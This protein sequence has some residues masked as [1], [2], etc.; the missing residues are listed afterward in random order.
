MHAF[1]KF[2]KGM[3]K[4]PVHWQLWLLFLVS[5]NL[6]VPLFFL[7]RIEALLVVGVLLL[8]MTLMTVLTSRFGFTRILGLGHILWVPLLL[9]LSTRL[10]TIPPDDVYGLWIRALITFN[11]LSLVIDLV[12]LLRYIAGDRAETVPGL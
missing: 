11:A 3:I 2:N 6:V 4:M 5:M 9:F 7:K 8:S 1:L 12:D 10:D